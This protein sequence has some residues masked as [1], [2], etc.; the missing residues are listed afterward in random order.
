MDVEILMRGRDI[1]KGIIRAERVRARHGSLNLCEHEG[2]LTF[3][4]YRKCGCKGVGCQ[5]LKL[6]IAM[7][8]IR[9]WD[10]EAGWIQVY[11]S[12]EP[13][14]TSYEPANCERSFKPL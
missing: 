5:W 8:S 1:F 12:Y 6:A 10:G 2:L 3:E 9:F 4:F 11:R 7:I 14:A 13:R